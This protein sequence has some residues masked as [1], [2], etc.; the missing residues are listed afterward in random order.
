MDKAWINIGITLVL[1]VIKDSFKNPKAK[2]EFKKALKKI[3]DQI[4]L[5]YADD[6][7]F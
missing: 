5:L 1:S 2:E 6:P 7:E 4:N 3:R